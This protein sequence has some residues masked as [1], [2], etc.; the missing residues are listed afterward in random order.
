MQGI[1]RYSKETYVFKNDAEYT[2]FDS[3]ELSF[4]L[5]TTSIV[6]FDK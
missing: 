2:E 5:D 6:A 1:E 3:G 4:I